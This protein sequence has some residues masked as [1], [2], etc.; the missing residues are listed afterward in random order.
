M[1]IELPLE[2]FVRPWADGL[3]VLDGLT[4]LPLCCLPLCCCCPR[5]EDKDSGF[6]FWSPWG[7]H[8]SSRWHSI[9]KQTCYRWDPTRTPNEQRKHN[10]QGTEPAVNPQTRR[11]RQVCRPTNSQ[12]DHQ[13]SLE[14]LS[15]VNSTTIRMIHKHTLSDDI[16]EAVTLPTKITFNVVQRCHVPLVKTVES[17][18]SR[19]QG[20][21]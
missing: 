8:T 14:Q 2:R 13:S 19:W 17:I 4:F 18:V 9:P 1:T 20:L 11:W 7:K 6:E 15:R 5:R 12:E 21:R 3:F 10:S 16:L